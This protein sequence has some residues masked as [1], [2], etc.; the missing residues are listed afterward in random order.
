MWGQ[1]MGHPLSPVGA[2]APMNDM[3]SMWQPRDAVDM[4]VQDPRMLSPAA[5]LLYTMEAL[6]PRMDMLDQ[7]FIDHTPEKTFELLS[8]DPS[9]SRRVAPGLRDPPRSTPPHSASST[10]PMRSSPPGLEEP[11]QPPAQGVRDGLMVNLSERLAS[12]DA[13]VLGLGNDIATLKSDPQKRL[14]RI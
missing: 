10:E 1:Y 2:L 13:V 12:L 7:Q 9:P 3:T 6:E 11:S 5:N 14:H 4:L 8:L